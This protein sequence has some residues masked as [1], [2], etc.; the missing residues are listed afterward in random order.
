LFLFPQIGLVLLV[1]LALRRAPPWRS[2]FGGCAIALVFLLASF[3]VASPMYWAH[4]IQSGIYRLAFLL[5]AGTREGVWEPFETLRVVAVTT[6]PALLALALLG[7]LRRDVPVLLRS[8]I[9]LGVAV[10]LGRTMLPGMVNFDGVRHFWEFWPPTALL[11]GL[12]FEKLIRAVAAWRK[13]LPTAPTLAATATVAFGFPAFAVVD[14]FPHGICYFNSFIGGLKGAQARGEPQASD[15][16]AGSYWQGLE[17]FAANTTSS[18]KLCVPLHE[19]VARFA[20]PLRGISESRFADPYAPPEM[21]RL[22]VMF[23]TL[24]E[25][26]DDT[27]RWLVAERTPHHQIQ[28]QGAPILVIF[29]L[30]DRDD[31]ERVFRGWSESRAIQRSLR[32]LDHSRI[33]LLRASDDETMPRLLEQFPEHVRRDVE[34]AARV[35][36]RLPK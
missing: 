1:L 12:G 6:P 27:L 5:S 16:W 8:M 11:A 20:A 15:Y 32:W 22:Y 25:V 35:F 9:L 36:R 14:T 17:W 29:R 18:S 2:F 30:D 21:D 34:I 13:R 4:P 33:R 26:Y 3:W 7:A 31:I 23:T 24:S 28:V 10:P 19:H